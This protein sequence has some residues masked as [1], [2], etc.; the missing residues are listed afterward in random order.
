MPVSHEDRFIFIHIPKTAGSSV[1]EALLTHRPNL[2]FMARNS[3]PRL[4][5]HPRGVEMFRILR[6]FYALNSIVRFPEQHFPAR[7]VREM[8]SPEV[9]SSYFKFT[10]VRNPW[11][12]VVSAYHFLKETFRDNPQ[13]AADESD[14]AFLMPLVDFTTFVRVRRYFSNEY[15]MLAHV[16]DEAGNLLVDF[17]GRVER[18]DEDFPEICRRIGIDVKLPHANRSR[19]QQYREYYTAET[20]DIVARDFARDI[21][22]FGYSF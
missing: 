6:S 11:E 16:T 9:W 18:I 7:I 3:W 2:D 20:R 17:V 15:N 13:V 14:V 22:T 4:L 1:V 5:A 8:V 21:E 19:H 10:F 12:Q